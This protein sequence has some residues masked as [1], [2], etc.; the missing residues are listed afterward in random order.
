MINL[1]KYSKSLKDLFIVFGSDF[2]HK[3]FFTF[4]NRKDWIYNIGSNFNSCRNLS[5][6]KR[7]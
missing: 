6:R 4:G 1:F 5:R 2:I 7:K 3:Q